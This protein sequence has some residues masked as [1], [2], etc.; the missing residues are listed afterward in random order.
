MGRAARETAES[1]YPAV[2]RAAARVRGLIE[3]AADIRHHGQAG[4]GVG[5]TAPWGST[6][7]GCGN[8]AKADMARGRAGRAAELVVGAVVA[9]LPSA[10]K[11]AVYRHIFGYE[12]GRGVKIGLSPFVGVRR[13]RIGD[14][15]R[16]GHLNL[17]YHVDD[18]SIDEQVKIGF[19]NIFRGG[20]IRLGAYASIFR[21]NF[22]NSILEPDNDGVAYPILDVGPATVITS[23]HRIDFTDRISIG[24]STVI[25]GRGSALWTHSR[26]RT[27]PII[28]GAHCYLG[29]GVQIAP[30]VELADFCVVSLGAVLMGQFKEPR[31]LILG[32][33]ARVERQLRLDELPLVARSTRPDVPEDLAR[34]SL[35]DDLRGLAGRPGPRSAHAREVELGQ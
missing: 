26:Q 5:A 35:P 17:F 23:G 1:R 19:L 34:S 32:N 12:V 4:F 6:C 31:V 33:P 22:I 14:G 7:S 25:G 18:L 21:M 20:C 8:M 27:R 16:I 11:V 10:I 2:L 13:C 9:L 3:A 29:S 15:A 24:A 28:V 30:G